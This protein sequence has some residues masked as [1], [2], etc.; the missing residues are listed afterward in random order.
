MFKQLKQ[1]LL[2][3]LERESSFDPSVFDDPIASQTAWGP[4]KQGGANFR[5]HRLKIISERRLQFKASPGM[6]AFSAVFFGMGLLVLIIAWGPFDLLEPD[7]GKEI[8]VGIFGLIFAG[9]GGF[10]YYDATPPIVFDKDEN[11][12]WKGRRDTRREVKGARIKHV[13][14]LQ[15]IH[16]IQLIPERISGKSS[17]Y[18]YE[19]NL[20]LVDATRINVIDHGKLTAIQEEARIVSDFLG[21]PVWDATG[22]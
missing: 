22:R 18:S 12:F 2:A 17:Y 10:L 14:N 3:A 21:I 5:T 4:A 19:L 1:Q 16:A 20:V 8:L 6:I 7:R 15:D 9:V 11:V 13:A